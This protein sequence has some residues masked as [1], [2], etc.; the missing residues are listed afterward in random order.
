MFGICSPDFN[1]ELQ[2]QIAT[3]KK[4]LHDTPHQ[5]LHEFEIAREVPSIDTSRYNKSIDT[6][7]Y[8]KSIDRSEYNKSIDTSGYNKIETSAYDEIK[9]NITNQLKEK[10]GDDVSVNFSHNKPQIYHSSQ[11]LARNGTDSIHDKFTYA[12]KIKGI[13]RDIPREK[14]FAESEI[15]I[16]TDKK[17]LFIKSQNRFVVF[18]LL[19]KSIIKL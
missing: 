1:T 8:N 13:G 10:Y 9:Q 17:L 15:Y 12:L 19:R 16:N 6:S 18:P 4:L 14:D 3:L 2:N 5:M 7:G 11:Y